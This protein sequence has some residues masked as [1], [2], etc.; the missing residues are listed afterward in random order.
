VSS[1]PPAESAMQPTNA[2]VPA[3]TMRL[4]AVRSCAACASNVQPNDF[5]LA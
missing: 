2:A 5:P 4:L 3:Q 1:V